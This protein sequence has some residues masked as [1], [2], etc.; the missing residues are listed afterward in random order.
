[1]HLNPG[2]N[3]HFHH[4]LLLFA[5]G[6]VIN[7]QG[8]DS[9]NWEISDKTLLGLENLLRFINEHCKFIVK[10]EAVS[11]KTDQRTKCSL[12]I[13]SASVHSYYLRH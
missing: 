6:D 7:F 2:F 11:A 9:S 10:T 1:M 5:C 3:L 4:R 8:L 13:L 12:F